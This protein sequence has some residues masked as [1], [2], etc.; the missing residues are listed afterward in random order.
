M[1]DQIVMDE[2]FYNKCMREFKFLANGKFRNVDK[3]ELE[4]IYNFSLAKAYLNY[5]TEIGKVKFE[6]Y[7]LN[8]FKRDVYLNTLRPKKWEKNQMPM[9]DVYEILKPDEEYDNYFPDPKSS[10]EN[11]V[12][13]K[14]TMEEYKACVDEFIK[15]RLRLKSNENTVAEYKLFFEMWIE[16]FYLD[17]IVEATNIKRLTIINMKKSF[18]K[19]Y[20]NKF[21]K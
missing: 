11:T 19:K 12:I 8:I 7:L 2:K 6:T 16:G 1:A 10:I 4:S 18:R 17:D 15:L 3:V 20:R 13:F 9:V 14:E 21:V 5:D